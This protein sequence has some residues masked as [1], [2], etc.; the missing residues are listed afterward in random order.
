MIS[1]RFIPTDNRFQIHS[2]RNQDDCP[3]LANAEKVSSTTPLLFLVTRS[4]QGHQ[5]VLVK[6][7]AGTRFS[8]ASMQKILSKYLYFNRIMQMDK[9]KTLRH[10]KSEVFF[11]GKIRLTMVIFW[12]IAV[13]YFQKIEQF[14]GIAD[15]LG[16]MSQ[17]FSEETA[18]SF[19]VC[20]I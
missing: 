1:K 3:F 20:S 12:P 15:R 18:L 19:I 4:G 7:R 5:T 2:G 11:S 16:L 6:L 9:N 10:L 8:P 14:Y 13:R 17:F